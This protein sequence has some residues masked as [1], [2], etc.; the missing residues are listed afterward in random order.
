MDGAERFWKAWE[1]AT[2][3]FFGYAPITLAAMIRHRMHILLPP[4]EDRLRKAVAH[5][6]RTLAAQSSKQKAGMDHG[7]RPVVVGV[8]GGKQMDG[9]CELVDWVLRE[10][11]L[12]EVNTYAR[13]DRQIPGVFP[14]TKE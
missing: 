7:R 4:F 3:T 10:N 11:G 12:D 2:R 14:S 6:W 9:F 13:H 8:T 1:T 5:Y